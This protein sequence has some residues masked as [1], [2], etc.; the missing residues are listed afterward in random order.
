MVAQPATPAFSRIPCRRSVRPNAPA[1]RDAE[2]VLRPR[3][4][5]PRLRFHPR[6]PIMTETSYRP[7]GD[8]RHEYTE[9]ILDQVSERAGTVASEI[10]T[11]IKERP[12]TTLAVAAGLTFAVGALWKL[13][14]RRQPQSR[15]E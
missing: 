9:G 10:G 1:A 2:H 3:V 6:Y 12:Y 11:A 7:M 4:H 8:R 13:G 14:H 15:L 5:L